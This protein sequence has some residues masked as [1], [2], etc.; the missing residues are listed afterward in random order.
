MESSMN[1][2]IRPLKRGEELLWVSLGVEESQRESRAQRLFEYLKSNLDLAPEN[3]LLALMDGLVVGKMSGVLE[4][5]GY[6]ALKMHIDPKECKR[7]IASA[8]FSHVRP[9]GEIQ[10]LSWANREEDIEW[11]EL[12]SHCDFSI[13]QDKAY[14]KRKIDSF[15]TP[16]ADHLHYQSLREIG[17]VRMLDIY[18]KTYEGNLNRN[19]NVENPDG[20]LRSHIE[21]AGAL[22]NP[23]G[24]YAA[25]NGDSP[26]GILL[27][28]RFSDIPTEGTLMSIGI[29]PEYRRK[30]LG[31]I[32]HAKG[33][34]ILSK[35]GVSDYIGSTDVKNTAMIRVFEINGCENIGTRTT[36]QDSRKTRF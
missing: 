33:L 29:V 24:W 31:K 9:F 14:F 22:F 2:E 1:L 27:P 18:R 12:L 10:A 11:R 5:N 32:L 20:D 30:G 23:E 13:F 15:K 26:V 34:E 35:Q 8:L 17:E 21:S 28:Q 19:F 36:H 7:E 6:M 3:Y 16:Y 4:S 25:F